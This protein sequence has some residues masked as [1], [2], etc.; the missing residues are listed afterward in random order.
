M[1]SFDDSMNNCLF[2]FEQAARSIA[3]GPEHAAQQ[4]EAFYAAAW[5]LRQEI[6]VGSSL[7]AWDRVSVTLRKSIEHLVSVAT[8]LPKE[9]FAG[10]DANELFHPAWVQVRDA[11]TRFLAAA[12]AER[13]QVGEGSELG[14]GGP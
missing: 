7:L 8:D 4:F 11:A 14:G 1:I 10:Y 6:L 5:E 12:E 3:G 13:P 9:A 2:Y